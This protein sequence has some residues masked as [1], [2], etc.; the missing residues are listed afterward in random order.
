MSGG[1]I[2]AV[3]APPDRIVESLQALG[4][5][6]YETR[7]YLG[8]LTGGRQNGNELSRTSGVPSS[9]VYAM[10]ERLAADGIVARTRRGS[11]VEYV[12]VPPRDL[13]H[14]LRERYATPLEYLE[15]TLPTLQAA[16]PQLD[17]AELQGVDAIVEHARALIRSGENELVLSVWDDEVASLLPDLEDA[18]VRGVK[19]A[20]M[21]YGAEPPDVGWWQQHSYRETVASRIAGR[22]LTVVADGAEALIA[23]IA[24][25]REAS[26]VRTQNPVLV[27]VAEEYLIHELTLQRAKAWAGYDEYDRWLRSDEKLRELTLG[28]T[29][30]LSSVDPNARVLA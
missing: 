7:L 5:S 23:H 11:T 19:I 25:S 10:L 4:L 14:K 27:L 16:E 2:R 28:R 9:K 15:T 6:L 22:M 12:C 21:L 26:A 30:R 8:L 1:R 13:L 24:D 29:G 18:D 20:G 3:A 17:I